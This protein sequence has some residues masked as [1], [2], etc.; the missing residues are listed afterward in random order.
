M[1]FVQEPAEFDREH[2][3]GVAGRYALDPK[4][5]FPS[6]DS[7]PEATLNG[8]FAAARK[9]FVVDGYHDT[10]AFLL[11]GTLPVKILK[12]AVQEH[13]EKYLVMRML[14]NEVIKSR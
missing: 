6:I 1:E 11:S 7:A 13:G 4:E 14:A 8:L 12:L 10:I 9:M 3:E 5:M 2:V